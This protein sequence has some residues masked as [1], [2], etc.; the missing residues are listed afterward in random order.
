MFFRRQEGE[1]RETDR[2]TRFKLIKSGKHWLRAST[3]QFGLFKVLR[4]GVDAAQ[5]TTEVIEEQSAN[6]LTGL[7]ILKG[8]AAAGTVFGGA[9]ATQTTV[10]ANDALEKTV[11]SNQTLANTDTVTLGTVKDQE[12]AQADSL[13][14]SV[15]QSQSLSEEA[16]KNASKHL[17]E[18]ESQS[19]STSTSASVSAS[20]SASESASTSAS[21]SASTSASQSQT[22]VTSELAKPATSETAS[23]K[24]TSVR[25]EDTA[26]AALSKVITD[27]L[28]SLQAVE[29]RLSQITSTTSSLVDTTTT[30]AVATT[31]SA[32]SN[33]KAEEDRKRLSKISASMGEYLAKSIG[34][35][36]TEAAVAKVNAAVTAI[37]EALKTPNADLTD[38]IKQA[39]SAQN[40]IVN[41]VLRANN[42]KRSVLNGRQMERGVSFREV[43]PENTPGN[44]K[45]RGMESATVGYVISEAESKNQPLANGYKPGTYIYA[46]EGRQGNNQAPG[47]ANI[48]TRVEVKNIRNQ[49]FM[50]STRRGNTTE[51]EVTFN[52]NGEPHDNPYFYFTV[53]KGHTITYMEVWQKDKGN[54]GWNRLGKSNGDNAFRKNSKSEFLRAA[55]G[56]AKNNGGGSYYDNVAGVGPSGVGRG[57]LTSLRDFAFNNPDAYYQTDKISDKIKKA[58]DFAFNTIEEATANVY[59]LNPRGSARYEGYRIKYTTTRTENANDYYMAGFRSL[60]NSRHRNYLQMNGSP[61]RYWL[62]LKP[63]IP[64][65]FLKWSGE[66]GRLAPYD[67]STIA[68]VY[69]KET[70]QKTPL[71]SGDTTYE[72][73]GV[74]KDSNFIKYDG[75]NKRNGIELSKG[76]Y[77]LSARNSNGTSYNLPFKIVTLSDVYE[78]VINQSQTNGQ[79]S[80]G[81]VVPAAS[82]IQ[83]FDDKSSTIPGFVRPSDSDFYKNSVNNRPGGP[84]VIPTTTPITSGVVTEERLHVQKVEW[85]GGSDKI[86]SG[87]GENMAVKAIVDSKEVYLSVP[88]DM[89]ISRLGDRLTDADKRAILKYH[90]LDGKARITGTK[91]GLS[92]QLRT[93]YKDNVGGD[94]VDVSEVFFENVTKARATAPRVDPKSDGSVVVSPATDNDKVNISYTPTTSTTANT[95]TQITI[96]KSGTKWEN[97]DPL[98]VGVTLDK[99]TGHLTISEEAVKDK[100]NVTATSYNFNSDGT[101]TTATAKAPYQAKSGRFYAVE[102][103]DKNQL[104]ARDFVVDGDGGALPQGTSVK[105]KDSSLDLS[106]PGQRKATLL[107]TK[108]SETKEIEYDYTVHPKIKARTENGVTGKFFA[109][110]G[111]KEGNL[112]KV[113]GGQWA[114]PYGRNIEGYT[115]LDDLKAE[116]REVKWFYKYRLNGTDPEKTTTVGRDTFGEVWYT[117]KEE[118]RWADPVSHKTT[119]T[120][121]AVYPTGRF[122][123]ESD[124][125][126][127]L[128]S[129]TTFD[130]TVVDPVAKKVYETTVGNITPLSEIIQDPG[131]AIKNSRD[132]V[133]IPNGPEEATTTTYRWVSAPG[134]STVSTPGIKKADVTV[135]LPKGAQTRENSHEI[136]PVTIKVR[137]NP[138]QIANDQVKL[139]G[140]LPNRSITV[141]DVIPEATVALTIGTEIF[142]KKSTGTSVTFEQSDLKRVTDTNNG[143]LPTGD[144]MVKQSKEF[145]NPVTGQKETL[146]SDVRTVAITAETEKPHVSYKVTIDG[147]EPKKDSKGYYLFYAGDN[148]KVEFSATDNSGKLKKVTFNQGANELTN[149]F[150]DTTN[151]YGS[152]DV[153][154]IESIVNQ[155]QTTRATI[156]KVKDDLTYDSGHKWT[157]QIKAVDPSGNESDTNLDEAKFGIQ[158]GRLA[159]KFRGEQPTDAVVVANPNSLTEPERAKILAAVKAANPKDT[160]RIK[161][162]DEGYRISTDGTV[163]ITYKDGTSTTVPPKVKYGVEKVADK[164][165][166][167]SDETV[168]SLNPKDFVRGVG[169][170]PLPAGTTVTW[171][172][173]SEPTFTVGENRTAKLVVTYPDKRQQPDEIE[174]NYT[175][176]EKLQ[177]F[178]RNGFKGKFYAFKANQG[179]ERITGGNW[180]NNVG[181]DSY[182]Y[183]NVDKLPAGTKW[184]YKY[185]LN[186][187]G[188]EK[189]TPIATDKFGNVW[190]TTVETN[191]ENQ[192]TS[193]HTTYT[194]KAVYPTGRFGTVSSS[195]PALTREA[196]FEYTVVDPVAKKIYETTVGNKAPLADIIDTPGNA[197]VNSTNSVTIP[198]DTTYEWLDLDADTIVSAPGVYVRNVKM[199]LPESTTKPESDPQYVPGR[200]SEHVPITIKVKPKTP[201]IADD[202]VKLQGGLPNRSITVT[203]VTPGATVTLTIGNQTIKKEVP[204]GATS[205]TFTPP[206]NPSSPNKNNGEI[207]YTAFPNGVLPTG[208]ITVKQEKEVTLPGGGKETLTSGVTT[209]EITK[210]TEAPKVT[211]KVQVL[212]DGKWVDAPKDSQ[213]RNKIYAGDQFRVRVETWDNS[214]KVTHIEAWN[215]ET[216]EQLNYVTRNVIDHSTGGIANQ[217]TNKLTDASQ[218]QPYTHNLTSDGTY[219]ANQVFNPSKDYTNTATPD[220]DDT[221]NIWTRFARVKDLSGNLKVEKYVIV[222]APLSEKYTPN[223]PVI[224]VENLT[225]PTEADRNKI[226]KAIE[227]ANPNMQIKTVSVGRDGTVTVTYDDDTTDIFKPNLSDSDYRSQSASTSAV[228]STSASTSAVASTSA[229]TSAVAS[230][231]AS[232]SAVASTSASTSAVASTSASTSAVASAS[233]S[234]SAVASAS[235]STSAV[236][237]ASASTSAVASAS[238][239]TSAVASASAST[240]AVASTSMSVPDST[241]KPEFSL[242]ESASQSTSLSVSISTSVSMSTST[243]TS[244]SNAISDSASTSSSLVGSNVDHLTSHVGNGTGSTAKSRQQLPNTGTE[245][246]RTSALLGALAAVTGLGLFAKRRKRDNEEEM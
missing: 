73:E 94:S 189:T 246:S 239:S 206:I 223:S 188:E 154:K 202:Q 7:D 211:V 212:R 235:A 96:K 220:N 219:N 111:T 26:N 228:A 195:N 64:S 39:T 161:D 140:G 36:N 122:G 99:S 215:N 50:T 130:Y 29:N 72:I 233:A 198:R 163:T 78:P 208:E 68:D 171:K 199:I 28:A 18:S 113:G 185:Q 167:I 34:L 143:L 98:P 128:K 38:V 110:K 194:V 132:G 55:V 245:A 82:V 165:Y 214:G 157:R 126:R 87:V 172:K 164:F 60:E 136:V 114:N 56:N 166:A 79:V 156:G 141:T 176:Y 152:G 77:K 139:Q 210:E 33:K 187:T 13:S 81:Q 115:N 47:P 170:Q 106:T 74:S 21:E 54:T 53:P 9:V 173:G 229:S 124:P 65:T 48:A 62:E 51:W 52:N 59:A 102:G 30:V 236:A 22:G 20:T 133:P 224:Q 97:S 138:P 225:T 108:G 213:G 183:T 155:D 142:T 57:S 119:Y 43:A 15:S 44:P 232:T 12:G 238:A 147:K 196:T 127:A 123:A 66:V 70:G 218:A 104:N 146:E 159:D 67:I 23:N 192:P 186:N 63:G 112:S 117:T 69:D 24:E 197:I 182:L 84:E 190:H 230:T 118:S 105:W 191:P 61:E 90:D 174:Y 16:S 179:N 145:D 88:D 109:F 129:E 5:V 19:V 244:L 8:I 46:T 120:V 10:Y 209:K 204:A 58:G 91:I 177:T 162:G 93:I 92:K 35:P 86:G 17:S 207:D 45:Y 11:E 1:Y 80:Q 71:K 148:I 40:S 41:A 193:H 75:A 216:N 121:T 37:E 158:Q 100:T 175:V 205:V 31:V 160:N 178:T 180:A 153:P 150:N 6:T 217:R 27:S 221:P 169:N 89:D 234:T 231:S 203:D 134:D 131:K 83:K 181:R 116:S 49:V 107:V 243:S 200:N 76:E 237:S 242:S 2:V 42:G 4:G 14:V 135:T 85:V 226:R 3:S 227:D 240:S 137:P 95:P 144:V 149:F 32:E 25:K 241:D 201:Q 125:T 151:T 103:E 101:T 184:S 222:Q 168:A